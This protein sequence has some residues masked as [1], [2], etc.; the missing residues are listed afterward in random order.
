MQL[1][2]MKMR[3]GLQ[4]KF[5][6]WVGYWYVIE[7]KR[8]YLLPMNVQSYQLTF[9]KT[10]STL[11]A[12]GRSAFI[13]HNIQDVTNNNDGHLCILIRREGVKS[14]P[15]CVAAAVALSTFHYFAGTDFHLANLSITKYLYLL[16]WC[17][18][19]HLWWNCQVYF[20]CKHL[21]L[22]WSFCIR[23]AASSH[24]LATLLYTA[25]VILCLC[26]QLYFLFI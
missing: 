7:C 14:E 18:R 22:F 16:Y 2:F 8:G 10:S 5:R 23:Q 9:I 1:G 6:G 26:G 4:C 3:W 17:R 12:S 21:V 24:V 13:K 19:S 25:T 20:F 11:L 15:G